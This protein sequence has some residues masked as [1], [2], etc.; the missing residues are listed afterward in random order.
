MRVPLSGALSTSNVPPAL[1]ARSR[2]GR[3]SARVARAA[4]ASAFVSKH[5]EAGALLAAIRQR[6]A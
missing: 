2:I 5:D 4:G 6:S 3:I 1:S